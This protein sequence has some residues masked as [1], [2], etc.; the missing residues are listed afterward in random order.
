MAESNIDV[1]YNILN[2]KIR[3]LDDISVELYRYSLLHS[4]D[5]DDIIHRLDFVSKDIKLCIKVMRDAIDESV[6]D[7]IDD[8]QVYIDLSQ[9]N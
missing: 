1:M 7:S 6:Y 9:G 8:D 5:I 2:D 3:E 4:N